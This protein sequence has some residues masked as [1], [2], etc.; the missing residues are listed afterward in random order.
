MP[1]TY[2]RHLQRLERLRRQLLARLE[3]VSADIL[4]QRPVD[5]G[6]S[7]AQVLAHVIEAER[8]S[9]DYVRKKARDPAAIPRRRMRQ[10]LNDLLL[11]AAMKSPFKFEAP[12]A[13]AE[14]PETLDLEAL[15]ADWGEVRRG[16]RRFVDTFPPGL[17]DKT[18]YRHPVAG[19]LTLDAALRF[20][21]NHLQR[22]G[23]QI[24]RALG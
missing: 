13:L 4:N 16:W 17:A 5:G 24:E 21:V 15:V 23:R 2:D 12:P 1:M 11:Q 9:L 6:W 20:L 22:H 3:G 18:V 19:P 7:P 10:R 14:P 8:K